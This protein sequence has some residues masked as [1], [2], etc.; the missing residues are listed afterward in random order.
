MCTGKL[1]FQYT[2]YPIK[3]LPDDNISW[4]SLVQMTVVMTGFA[5]SNFAVV[6]PTRDNRTSL[7]KVFAQQV[8]YVGNGRRQLGFLLFSL[9][10]ENDCPQLDV[11]SV[12]HTTK[13]NVK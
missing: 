13:L 3:N 7:L 4:M 1:N 8:Q 5:T 10:A 11:V 2:N 9:A 6:R 12:F